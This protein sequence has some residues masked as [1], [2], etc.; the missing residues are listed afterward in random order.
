MPKDLRRYTDL[1][2][3][4]YL[5]AERKLTLLDPKGWD[6][7][8]DSYCLQQYGKAKVHNAVFALCFVQSSERYHLW[9]VFGAGPSG[10]RIKFKRKALLEAAEKVRGLRH[11]E[12]EYLTLKELK[13][14]F[15]ADRL[16]FLKRYA[17][18]DEEEYRLVYGSNKDL[19]K[20]DIAIP[21]DCIESVKLNPWLDADSFEH[22]RNAIRKV[23]SRWRNLKVER[24]TLIDNERWREFADRISGTGA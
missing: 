18:L 19:P 13:G 1:S 23:H 5:L 9:K 3:V 17:F 20:F 22:V 11:S 15:R 10:V 7:K 21:P 14:S 6:D 12:V 4:F 2:R 16:P 8:N 24:S